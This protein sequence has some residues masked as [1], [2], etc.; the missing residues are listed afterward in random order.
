[1]ATSFFRNRRLIRCFLPLADSL[2]VLTLS[3]CGGGSSS[4]GPG[5]GPGPS[6]SFSISVT[7]QNQSVGVGQSATLTLSVSAVSGFNQAIQ[8]SVTG[9]PNGVTSS[10]ASPFSMTISGQPVT[11]AAASSASI[12]SST[13][14]F[15]AT[16]GSLSSSAQAQISV[17]QELP[18]LSNNRT[19]FVR[20]DD[21][22]GAV[23]YDPVHQLIFASALDLNC[24]DVIPLATQQVA[25]C[26]PV[27]G[28]LGLS[29]SADGTQVL[30]GTQVGVVA[31]IDAASLR[32]VRR[33]VIPQIPNPL[34]G[35]GFGFVSATQAFQVSNGKVL[36]FSLPG[37]CDVGTFIQSVGVVE[38]DPVA[39]TSTARTDSGGGGVVST[40]LDHSKLLVAGGGTAALYDSAT[41]QFTTVPGV[42]FQFATLNPTGSQFVAVGGTPF[43]RF[44]N[45]QMQQVGSVDFPDC[46]AANS[47]PP[48]AVYSPDGKSLYL[49][50]SSQPSGLSKLV[51]VDVAAFK[52]VGAAANLSTEIA[53]FGG[54]LSSGPPQAGDSTGLVFEIADH[55]VGIVDAGDVRTF[56]NPQAVSNFI[57]ATPDE[58]PLNQPTTTQFTTGIFSTVPDVFFGNQRGLNP[59]LF[60][61]AGQLE[62][63][64]PP[65]AIA[66]PV[67]VKAVESNG[68]TAFMP[69]AFTYGS[70]PVQYGTLASDPKGGVLA[71]L[72][73]YGFSVDIPG[74]SIQAS[75][76]GFAAQIQKKVLLPAEIPYPFPL[77]HL[78]V[79]I[80]SGSIGAQDIKVTSQTGTATASKAFH[81]IKS[82]VDFPSPDSFLYVLY[83]PPRNQLYLSATD[84]IDVFSLATR[85]FGSPIAVPSKGGTRLI[86]GLTLTPDG[87]KLLAANQSDQSV[88]IINP[89]NP[90]VNAVAI[91]VPPTPASGNPG[92]FQIA[93][94]ST[95][96]AFITLTVG[97]A[98]SGG[99]TSIYDLDL[100]SLQVTTPNLPAGSIVNLNNN[101]IQASTDG[102]VIIEATSNNSGGPLLSWR[103]ASNTWQ[104]HLVEGQFWDNVATSGDG[105]VLGVGSSPDSLAFPFPYLLDPQLHLTGQVNF[106][107]FQSIQEGPTLQIDQNGALLYAVN[108]AGVDIMDARTGQLRERVLL[109]EQILNGPREV[110]QTPSKTMAITPTG[111]QIFLL[112][113]AGL[114]IVDLDSVPLGIGSVTPA[115]GAAGSLVSIRGTGFVAG[116]SITVNGI[117]ASASFV[118]AST[119]SVTIPAGV[120]KGA[121]QFTLTTPDGSKFSLDDAFQVL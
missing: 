9:L 63:T 13:V 113:T 99:S 6:P 29:L 77:Q 121:A 24:V 97:N 35:A 4:S 98:L 41:D 119:L 51:T 38:W 96:H 95:G 118:D 11:L 114:T 108:G 27:S 76:G 88:A 12:G 82:V 67:N 70:L 104:V 10:P 116:T 89:D 40:T 26:I 5:P 101:Y 60:N 37:C 54:G 58:G 30:V 15:N 85:S 28:A 32:V 94:T 19:S 74:A 68:V 69:Q 72:L 84:H 91:S 39:G 102:T 81:Y 3:S 83:D 87:S 47:D 71:D 107:E 21:T 46:C 8:V 48:F 86:L 56:Q 79:T 14:K 112:T 66:G 59:N 75:V 20:T 53:Y 61:G 64:A 34:F 52:I 50:Y 100:S 62:A 90:T 2:L 117:S 57:I 44:F 109:A 31:W 16:S 1:M 93:T 33:D 105:S 23:L 111:D 49:A 45:L 18:G 103:A 22:P 106:P 65:S 73:G 115:S 78:V 7:P 80:P 43:L 25:Q 120:Q 110:L 55:G 36:L 17:V 92:P 42:Q